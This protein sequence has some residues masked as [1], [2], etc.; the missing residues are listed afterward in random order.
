MIIVALVILGLCLGSFVNALVYRLYEQSNK[1]QLKKV[2]PKAKSA[3]RPSV[4]ES[5][6]SITRGRSMCPHCH[7]ILTWQDL[8][9]VL[10]WMRLKGRCRYCRKPISVQYPL[11]E[12]AATALF[13]CSF[14]FWPYGFAAAGSL[15]FIVWLVLLVGFMA[16]IVYDL[17]WFILPNR[18]VYPLIALVAVQ[19]LILAG[20]EGDTS[21]LTGAALGVLV[22]GGLFYVLFQVSGG[23][24]IGGGDVKLGFLLGLTVGG[25]VNGLL[26]IFL[27]SIFGTLASA[28]LLLTGRLSR[29]S[30]VPFGPSLIMAAIV[31]LLFGN[32][33][34]DWYEA[35]FSLM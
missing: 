31:V 4:V 3:N 16:L 7:H 33:M 11:V 12:L 20:I 23:R 30:H 32:R 9:P 27:A 19:T 13:V 25:P 15:R 1:L 22:G 6:L 24:W 14:I 8:I 26:L 18:I 35:S 5:N 34:I 29:K 17:R 2:K 28:P 10:S 21:I